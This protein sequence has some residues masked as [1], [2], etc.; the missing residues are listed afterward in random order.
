M[1]DNNNDNNEIDDVGDEDDLDM[2]GDDDFSPLEDIEIEDFSENDDLEDVQPIV[3]NPNS[4]HKEKGKHRLKYDSIFKG[5]KDEQLDE[6]YSTDFST[7]ANKSFEPD[8]SSN[9]SYEKENPYEHKRLNDLREEMHKIISEIMVL[10]VSMPRRKPAKSAFNKNYGI[11]TERLDMYKY[12]FIEVFV[13]FS[14]YFSDNLTSMM[15]LLD[16]DYKAV[17]AEEVNKKGKI[18]GNKNLEDID[19]V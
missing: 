2:F 1:I 6:D 7:L 8:I 3:P 5:K 12:S 19:F 15:K 10:D 11:L 18:R 4:K 13:E 17:I 14:A 9:Y 16:N